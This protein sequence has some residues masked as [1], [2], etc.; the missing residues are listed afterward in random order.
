MKTFN[1][2]NVQQPSYE[3]LPE[4]R[5]DVEV[6]E[7]TKG[8]T[9]AGDV[10]LNIKFNVV[11]GL[12]SDDK[13]AGRVLWANMSLGQN[14]IGFFKLFLDAVGSDLA[15]GEDVTLD[16]LCNDLIGK[17]ASCM[18]QIGTTPAGKSKNDLRYWKAIEGSGAQDSNINLIR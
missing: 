1:F 3:P 16:D 10:M 13:Y 15:E 2:K 18:A 12:E 17:R 11:K 14:A 4:D 9:T 6:V 7:I 8:S 5:Y